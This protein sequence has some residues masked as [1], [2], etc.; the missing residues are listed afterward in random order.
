MRQWC[1]H[2]PLIIERG[3]GP[4]L[5][6]LNGHRY[7]DGVSS[8]WCNVH[9]HHV[10]AIDDAVTAQLNKIAHTTLLGLTSPPAIE[11]AARL[12][13]ITRQHLDRVKAP[14]KPL[15]AP[16]LEKNNVAL[17]AP[18]ILNK[19]FYS[20]AG[21][22]AL[23]VAFKIAVGHWHHADQP[24]KN[25]FIGL[26]GAYHG[27]TNAAMSVGY[28][29]LF[30]RAFKSMAFD[31]DWFPAPDACRPPA[32]LPKIGRTCDTPPNAWP[33]EDPALCS[34]LTDH[35]LTAL[36][37][38]LER[39]AHQTAA[40]VIEPVMQGAAGMVCQPPGFVRGVAQLA[41]KHN[42]LLI[43]DEVAVG[44][45]RTGTL[46]ACEH[47][48][49]IP[50]ILCLAKG[51]TAGYLPLAVTLTTDALY[52]SFCGTPD[53]RKTLYH[54][55]TYTG[56]P[57]ACAAALASLD[58]FNQPLDNSPNLLAHIKHSAQLI[59]EHL[60]PLRDCSMVQDIRQRGIMVGIELCQNRSA[61]GQ[62]EPFDFSKSTGAAICTALRQ[63][64]IIIR[65]LGDILV[66][67]PIPATPHDILADMV[68]T[69]VNTVIHWPRS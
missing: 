9:G 56:N 16:R 2:D 48:Q 45:G 18:P 67:M 68:D 4:Y 34:A 13:C 12:A 42:V 58:L 20:D 62:V 32:D 61:S 39:Q 65:P 41:K 30:H 17:L 43:A 64:G 47:D 54:G 31:V 60:N 11:L 66:L 26:Q 37:K 29:D 36:R 55:H 19:V 35:C 57:L 8:L 3:E 25:R 63:K 23:E 59:R 51:I 21:A 27:D 22:T 14:H 44:F 24:Q 38:Q 50:D 53:E 49:I 1:E 40:I 7:L 6:D 69:V 46:F 28:S 33:S 5:F 10:R 52:E 15:T